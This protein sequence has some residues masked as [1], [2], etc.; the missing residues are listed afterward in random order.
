M[1]NPFDPPMQSKVCT[2]IQQSHTHTM[3]LPSKWP[4]KRIGELKTLMK[5]GQKWW[6]NYGFL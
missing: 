4:A 6:H 5:I 1:Q 2:V 3:L